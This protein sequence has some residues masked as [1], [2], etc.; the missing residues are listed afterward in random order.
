VLQRYLDF[1]AGESDVRKKLTA[2]L[3]YPAVLCDGVL[4]FIFLIPLWC[5][6]RRAV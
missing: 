2:S 1:P 6:V 4:L 5:A 3:I